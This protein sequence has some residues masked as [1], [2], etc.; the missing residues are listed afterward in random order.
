M[1]KADYLP[2]TEKVWLS[3]REA[4]EYLGI[5]VATLYRWKDMGKIRF[6]KP[7]GTQVNRVLREA[8]DELMQSSDKGRKANILNAARQCQNTLQ[9]GDLEALQ[10]LI[11]ESR[12]PARSKAED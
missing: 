6:Y 12:M 1:A 11:A 9:L 4:A 10:Q 5:S 2:I 7:A 3:P 8:L